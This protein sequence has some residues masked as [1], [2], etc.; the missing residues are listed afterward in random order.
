M[1]VD[2]GELDKKITIVRVIKTQ[3]ADGYW[4]STDEV[5]RQPWAKFSR[6]SGREIPQAEADYSDVTVRFLIR[7]SKMP[8]SRKMVVIYSGERYEIKYLN[9][10]GDQHEFVEILAARETMEG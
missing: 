2:A 4:T 7:A 10:Y 6:Q 8:L 1:R 9:D 5:V 3:D